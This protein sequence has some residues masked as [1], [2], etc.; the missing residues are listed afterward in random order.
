MQTK[1][2]YVLR[3][4]SWEIIKF[5][6]L[7]VLRV[8]LPKC[9]FQLTVPAHGRIYTHWARNKHLQYK[10]VTEYA[11]VY[12]DDCVDYL[13]KRQRG[14][15]RDVPRPQEWPER[16][17]RLYAREGE[18]LTHDSQ[19]WNTDK[20]KVKD[21]C[22]IFHAVH[23]KDYYRRQYKILTW[24]SVLLIFYW[25]ILWSKLN[26]FYDRDLPFLQLIVFFFS[27]RAV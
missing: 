3:V 10:Y 19:Y 26:Y 22:S 2:I 1:T 18:R 24:I 9:L 14:I 11:N 5:A 13:N 6:R 16:V 7:T 25:T 27:W 15:E 17:L 8:K 20:N 23:S 12:F 21:R 4:K